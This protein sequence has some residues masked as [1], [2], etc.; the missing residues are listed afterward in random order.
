[1]DHI[2]FNKT[3]LVIATL[4][5]LL[6]STNAVP[7]SRVAPSSA[8]TA[9]PLG[10]G[11]KLLG[12]LLVN[13]A[14]KFSP[15]L[16]TFCKGADNQTQ[17]AETIAPYVGGSFDPVKLLEAKIDATLQK[18]KE[19]AGKIAKMLDD[20][21]TSKKA[22]DALDICK[23]QYGS[24][25]GTL[26]KLLKL[27]AEQNVVDAYYKFSSVVSDQS[28]CE[29][30]F[31]ESPGVVYPLAKDTLELTQLG[32]ICLAILNAINNKKF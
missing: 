17:C 6:L 13:A 21:A 29:D 23:S 32:D 25:T 2:R 18:A 24:M 10:S 14:K 31:K 5:C 4:S 9:E 20:P 7:S 12:N 8:P 27:V 22:L 30:A 3:L 15:E 1:M 11:V 19:I 26:K 28:S 16:L